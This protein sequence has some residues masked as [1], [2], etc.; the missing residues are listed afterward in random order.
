MPEDESEARSSSGDIG[1]VMFFGTYNESFH[2]RVRVLREGLEDHGAAVTVLNE[3]LDIGTAQRIEMLRNPV[4]VVRVGLG[5]LRRWF[6]LVRKARRV[7]VQPAVV[8]VG[9]LGHFDVLLARVLFRRATVVLDHMV[10]LADTANDRRLDGSRLLVGILGLVDRLALRAADLVIFDT[11]AQRAHLGAEVDS[12]LVVPVGAPRALFETIRRPREPDAP[13]RVLFFGL[14]TPLQGA[15][16]IGAA[17]GLLRDEP[18][19]RFTMVGEGQDHSAAAAAAESNPNVEWIKWLA[20]DELPALIARCDVCLGIFGTTPKAL[21][22]VPNKVYQGLATGAAILTSDTES[23][24]SV[25]GDAAHYV[26]PGDPVALA[27]ALRNFHD[28]P[29]ML[30]DLQRKALER[31][32]AAFT[33]LGATRP[34]V[35][36]LRN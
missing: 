11:P 35:D 24:R 21:R 14:F 30:T 12:G 22:V 23:Q 31:G 13:L 6:D 26:A 10:G 4:R 36:R 3:P 19:V 17:I 2:P 32:A 9:Y 27:E 1:P 25:I 34:L 8:I 18:G 20:S 7:E 15:A 28:D 16:T 33:P 5:V 29:Q